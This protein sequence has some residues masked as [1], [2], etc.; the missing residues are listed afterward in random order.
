L[1]K[2]KNNGCFS[3]IL[4]LFN[5]SPKPGIDLSAYSLRG[6]I[7]TK[8]EHAFYQT[9]KEVVGQRYVIFAKV[10]LSDMFSIKSGEKYQSNLNRINSKHLDFLLCDPETFKPLC[11]IE[12]DDRSHQ[13]STRKKRDEFVDSLFQATKLP[14]LRIPAKMKYTPEYVKSQIINKPASKEE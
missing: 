14:L 13:R 6:S 10:R 5:L 8:N 2:T 4:D 1:E 7:F 12:L 11:G 3:L 9:L